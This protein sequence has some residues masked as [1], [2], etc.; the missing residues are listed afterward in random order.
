MMLAVELTD[1]IGG[2]NVNGSERCDWHSLVTYIININIY[3]KQV[4][5]VGNRVRGTERNPRKDT[6]RHI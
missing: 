4:R 2:K 5:L 3:N 1:K 6:S